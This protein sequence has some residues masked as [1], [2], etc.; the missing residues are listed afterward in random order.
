MQ[1]ML[2]C[3]N[4]WVDWI[5]S[6]VGKF[7]KTFENLKGSASHT[8]Y[9]KTETKV[10]GSFFRKQLEVRS[11]ICLCKNLNVLLEICVCLSKIK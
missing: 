10:F 1:R 2:F 9:F 7:Y 11:K 6:F 3:V 4:L 8:S 5:N